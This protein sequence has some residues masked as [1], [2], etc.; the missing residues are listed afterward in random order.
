MASL[1][2]RL[3]LIALMLTAVIDHAAQAQTYPAKPIH[4]IV[5]FAPGGITD[6]VARALG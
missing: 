3:G 2:C 6:V 4:I 5:P 1:G